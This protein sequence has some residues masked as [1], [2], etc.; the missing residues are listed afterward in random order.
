LEPPHLRDRAWLEQVYRD[1]VRLVAYVL[2][3]LGATDEDC[4]EVIQDVFLKLWTVRREI[5]DHEALGSW[6]TSAARN[7]LI[8][9]YRRRQRTSQILPLL[10]TWEESLRI[11]DALDIR[12]D[13]VRAAMSE[14]AAEDSDREILQWFYG[15]PPLSVRVIAQRLKCRVSTVTSR[16]T[17][18]RARIRKIV[19]A[20]LQSRSPR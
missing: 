18:L 3:R 10:K 13:V 19:C 16:L 15:E 6:L 7:G 2:R 11:A 1:R 9:R 5:R 14:V 20:K 8:D 12:I 17:R 4:D